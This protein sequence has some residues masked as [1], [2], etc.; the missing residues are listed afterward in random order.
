MDKKIWIID[1]VNKVW[2]HNKGGLHATQ[3]RNTSIKGLPTARFNWTIF[4]GTDNMSNPEDKGA[5][6]PIKT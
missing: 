3:Y 5:L 2:V 1:E 4:T 6:I